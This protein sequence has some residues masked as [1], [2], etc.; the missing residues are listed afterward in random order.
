MSYKGKYKVK[1]PHKYLGDH[2][3][4]TFR[5]LLERSFMVYLEESPN[6][7]SWNSEEIVVPY[8]SPF[9]GKMHRYFVDFFVRIKDASGQT[10]ELLIEI[11]PEKQCSAPVKKN[12]LK[13][14]FMRE[15]Y[16]YG[17]NQAKWAA[18]TKFAAARGW[19]FIVLT[20]KDVHDKKQY[21]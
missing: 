9:D 17:V 19:K 14:T 20:E 15:T 11:K 8:Y 3:T 13:R 1:Y 21:I 6:V 16:T 12:Q 18:A 7:V 4:V 5:S 2:T 10:K